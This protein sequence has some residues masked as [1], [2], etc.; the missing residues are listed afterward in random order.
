MINKEYMGRRR[1]DTL[2]V[3][4]LLDETGSMYKCK[5]DTIR[6]FND[7]IYELRD[8]CERIKFT[9]TKFNSCR[10]RIVHRDVS[11][12]KVN[13]LNYNNYKPRCNTPLYDAIGK[14]IESVRNRDRV[15]FIVQTDGEENDS[16]EYGRIDI[17]RLVNEYQDNGWEFVFLGT[18]FGSW[19]RAWDYCSHDLG[20]RYPGNVINYGYTD[21]QKIMN[22]LAGHTITYSSCLSNTGDFFEKKKKSTTED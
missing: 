18:E 16:K 19:G 14:T 11:L 17:K 2:S 12:S 15:L 6:G 1:Y 4:F 8:S 20:F 9:L 7:Y 10:T 5:R 3:V 22:N 21:I 13:R